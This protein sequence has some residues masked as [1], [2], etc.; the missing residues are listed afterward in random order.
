MRISSLFLTW[1]AI[2]GVSLWK[3]ARCDDAPVPFVRVSPRDP[4]Y[5][6]TDD[7]RPY[8]PIGLN[9]ISPPWV[10]SREPNDRLAALDQ[11]LGKLAANGG[12]HIRAWLS[13]EF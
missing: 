2:G 3:E 10:R 1:L 4:H 6:E 13:N 8:I 9:V 7:G 5:F 12:N 11:W